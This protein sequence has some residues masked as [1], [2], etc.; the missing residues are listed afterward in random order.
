MIRID[1]ADQYRALAKPAPVYIESKS[2]GL[3]VQV[4]CL[5]TILVKTTLVVANTWNPNH[6][7]DDKM[8]QLLQ[9]I[10]EYGFA[11]PVVTVFDDEQG[12]FVI[13]DGFHRR[14]IG[15]VDWL[16]LNY[17]P[18]VVLDLTMAQRMTATVAF[19]KARGV[20]Q[21]DLDAELIR[22]LLEQGLSDEEA[23]LKLGMDVDTVQRYKQITGVA[24]LFKNAE[25]SR[26][27]EITDGDD[28]QD[29]LG[30]NP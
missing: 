5:N 2:R 20:H 15:G 18:I 12:L 16:D 26:A 7:P 11:F 6:V 3:K 10:Q 21:V 4:P 23:A 24:S 30:S 25:Y 8:R 19:N 13:V 27:W 28:Y 29:S 17:I 9:S 14:T 22:S 1:T